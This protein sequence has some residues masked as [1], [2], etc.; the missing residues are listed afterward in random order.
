MRKANLAELKI[1]MVEAHLARLG[2]TPEQ[3][4]RHLEP[5]R[6]PKPNPPRNSKKVQ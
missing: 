3:I 6:R 1:K 2:C 4:E 5:M